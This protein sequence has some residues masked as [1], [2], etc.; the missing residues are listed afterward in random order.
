MGDG[1]RMQSGQEEGPQTL[2]GEYG[3]RR[4]TG[5][6]VCSVDNGESPDMASPGITKPSIALFTPP[7]HLARVKTGQ[8]VG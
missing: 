5:Q 8:G 2:M 1:R 3:H 4:V 7:G 6:G